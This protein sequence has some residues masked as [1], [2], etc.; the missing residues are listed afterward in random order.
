MKD[1]LLGEHVWIGANST[2]LK[3]V[4]LAEGTIVPYGSVIHKSNNEK[5]VVFLNKILKSDIVW[6]N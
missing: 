4:N 1:I 5:N 6:K 2:I 3:G